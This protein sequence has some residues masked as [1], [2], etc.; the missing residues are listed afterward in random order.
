MKSRRTRALLGLLLFVL[1]TIG[2]PA[3]DAWVLHDTPLANIAHVE[4]LEND[5]HAERCVLG[6][7]ATPAAPATQPVA[8]GRFIPAHFTSP[9]VAP[10]QVVRLRLSSSVLGSRAPPA[11][12]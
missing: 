11:L 7:P 10:R 2:V 4:S 1:G 6:A 3:F 9:P 8:T 5:C 12:I